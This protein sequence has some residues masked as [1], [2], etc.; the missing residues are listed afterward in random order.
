MQEKEE[1]INEGFIISKSHKEGVLPYQ[2]IGGFA[3]VEGFKNG[4]QTEL[5]VGDIVIF[6]TLLVH[7]SG[8]ILD[9]SIRW[10]CHFR[11]TNLENYEYIERG[12]PNPYI[13]KPITK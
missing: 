1:L 12:F 3:T 8:D 7:S 10:S 11:Y 6:S 2:N 5:E 4:L 13:Y 9:N